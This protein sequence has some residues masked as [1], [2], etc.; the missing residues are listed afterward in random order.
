M[1][2]S[3]AHLLSSTFYSRISSLLRCNEGLT[4]VIQNSLCHQKLHYC[5]GLGATSSSILKQ[6]ENSLHPR[7]NIYN[8][9]RRMAFMK[10]PCNIGDP[11]SEVETPSLLVCLKSL[12]YNLKKMTETMKAFPGVNFRTHAKTHKCP[13]ISR[14]QIKS[15]AVGVCCQTLTEAEAMVEGG[16]EDI[17]L[18]NQVIGIKKLRRLAGLA[19]YA[20]IAACVDSEG[21]IEDL[22]Q[23]ARELGVTVDVL[24]EV[25][26]G[27]NRC[28]VEPGDSVLKLAEKI[29]SLPNIN[30]KGLQCYNGKIQHIRSAADRKAAV[31]VVIEKT[32]KSIKALKDR[33]IDCSYITGGGT[34]T[35]QYEASSG[36]F[37]EVQP[38]SYV[39]MDVDYGKNL[40]VKEQ[41][42][43]DFQQS[44]YVLSTVQ[45]VAAGDRA[46]LDAGLK[47]HS[48][49]SGVP[50][51]SGHP[52]LTYYNGGDEHGVVI[53][54]GGLKVG[55]LVW[56]I[57]GH[58]DPTV[59]MHEWVVGL[60]DGKVECIWP[61][62]GRGPGK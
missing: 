25:N 19:R 32:V 62:S 57:P 4:L 48:L 31:G 22:S 29:K 23:A 30:F 7:S 15:G 40:D 12:E 2:Q 41:F 17:L 44:L 26:V 37:T 11:V 34:G 35:F 45:S 60:R 46:I 47:A 18:S 55:D 1:H 43:S 24:V 3:S 58:C 51:L 33:G 61:V 53:P 9:T 36:V 56:L 16:I 52:D 14:L 54:D 50:K 38:G 20:K 39:F 10:T 21:N 49:D 27:G 6:S 5:T 13:M 42:V 8:T 59:N 28:G